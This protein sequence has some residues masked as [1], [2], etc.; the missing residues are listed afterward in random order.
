MKIKEK[1]KI[2]EI[3]PFLSLIAVIVFFEIVIGSVY[4]IP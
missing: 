3:V 1:I 4:K 2:R